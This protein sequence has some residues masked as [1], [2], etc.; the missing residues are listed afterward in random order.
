MWY[1][2]FYFYLVI[3]PGLEGGPN[4]TNYGLNAG[5]S[6][7]RELQN[8]GR[9]IDHHSELAELYNL[10]GDD[11]AIGQEDGDVDA[12]GNN[13]GDDANEISINE[14]ELGNNDTVNKFPWY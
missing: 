4:V 2:F 7:E 10:V 13:I 6:V 1:V 9:V 3:P 12:D 14:N 11:D 8:Y 5:N